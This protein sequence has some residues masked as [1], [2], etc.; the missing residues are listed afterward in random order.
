MNGV[1]FEKAVQTT[2]LKKVLLYNNRWDYVEKKYQK[3]IKQQLKVDKLKSRAE[4]EAARTGK[5]ADGYD[6]GGTGARA[7]ETIN[8]MIYYINPYEREL[9]KLEKMKTEPLKT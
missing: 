5:K 2:T 4:H 9:K 8:L 3:V 1:N 6:V 7:A